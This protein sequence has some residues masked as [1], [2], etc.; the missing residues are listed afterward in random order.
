V[1]AKPEPPKEVK[2]EA[3]KQAA[4]RETKPEPE[5]E[6]PVVITRAASMRNAVKVF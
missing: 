1:E 4:P 2:N 3:P 5:K 6:R